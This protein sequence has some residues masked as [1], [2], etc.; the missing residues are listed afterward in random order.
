MAKKLTKIDKMSQLKTA[1]QKAQHT[2]RLT[3]LEIHPLKTTLDLFLATLRPKKLPPS[4]RTS[5]SNGLVETASSPS[6]LSKIS[7]NPEI[8][9]RLDTP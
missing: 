4:R 1:L 8:L 7:I 3:P 6:E 5:N 2:L 9:I